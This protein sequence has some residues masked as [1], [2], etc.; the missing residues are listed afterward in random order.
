VLPASGAARFHRAG[1]DEPTQYLALHPLGPMA[2]LM[3]RADL[4]L[5][6]QLLAVSTRTWALEV[7]PEGLVA[8]DFDNAGEF[9]IDPAGLV[10]EDWDACQRLAETLRGG[11]PG[12]IVP[13]AALP[14]TRNV[15]LFGARV[16]SPYVTEPMSRLDVPAS[17][18]A[19]AARPPLSL[20]AIVRFK[21][22][23][24]PALAAWERGESF[25]FSEPDW[26]LP[27]R[28][29]SGEADYALP[30]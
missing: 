24:H 25:S 13:S 14:G 17:I 8:I 6:D 3:R 4:R 15:V 27:V 19:D 2:E 12:L 30:A 10:G 7:D 20:T 18:T 1:A 28:A 16:A 26:S 11:A 21:G 29:T 9:G 5:P 23:P 22:Q